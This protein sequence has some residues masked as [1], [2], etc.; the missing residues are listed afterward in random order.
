[1]SEMAKNS[2]ELTNPGQIQSNYDDPYYLSSTD[3]PGM[4]LTTKQF[5]GSNHINWSRSVRRALATKSKI[6][7]IDGSCAK[8]DETSADY[9][10]WVRC[11]NMVTCWILN[12]MVPE[13]S[14]AFMYIETSKELWNEIS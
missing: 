10:R 9:T 11:D 4:Q 2:H 14:E 13:I 7:F 12:S 5:D 8:L 3:H 6:G 1:M